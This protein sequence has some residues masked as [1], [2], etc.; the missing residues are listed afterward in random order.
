MHRFF[1]FFLPR[2]IFNNKMHIN[3]IQKATYLRPQQLSSTVTAASRPN[4]CPQFFYL[5][6]RMTPGWG[7]GDARVYSEANLALFV[8]QIQQ[9]AV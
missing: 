5:Y 7:V 3:K 6:T 8:I 9:S 1:C 2:S 4:L